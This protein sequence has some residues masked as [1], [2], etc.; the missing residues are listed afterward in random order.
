[1]K[2]FKLKV[3]LLFIAAVVAGCD[4]KND[5]YDAYSEIQKFCSFLNAENIDQTIPIVN[6]F[7]SR[8][9]AGLDAEQQLTKLWAWLESCPCIID[10]A[11]LNETGIVFSFFENRKKIY[12]MDL[13]MEKSMKVTGYREFDSSAIGDEFCLYLNSENIDKT[14]PIAN[15]FLRSLSMS[16][17]YSRTQLWEFLF[18]LRSCPCIVDA[19]VINQSQ[20]SQSPQRMRISFDENGTRKS[21]IMNVSME[22]PLKVTGYRDYEEPPMIDEFCSYLSV[23]NID[24]TIPIVNQFLSGFSDGLDVKQQLLE[25]VDL[26]NSCPCIVYAAA[27]INNNEI[28]FGFYSNGVAKRFILKLSMDFPLT[29]TDLYKINEPKETLFETWKLAGIFYAETGVLKILE[30]VDSESCFTH[31]FGAEDKDKDKVGAWGW[32][33]GVNSRWDGGFEIDFTVNRIFNEWIYWRPSSSNLDENLFS[34]TI[35]NIHSFS[36]QDNNLRLYFNDNDY[37]LFF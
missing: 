20:I 21:I 23:E 30:P 28:S 37:L 33:R 27:D 22:N 29:V 19:I 32:G 9:P 3:F 17:P 26:L 14:I 1:M 34:R 8:L 13:L 5:D 31:T 25:L 6:R 35:K 15:K 10:V 18:W 12:F 36:V 4:R 11:V 24:N 16:I 2:S 7:L